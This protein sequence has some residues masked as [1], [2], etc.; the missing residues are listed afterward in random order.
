MACGFCATGQA[1]FERQL[2]VGEIV[3]QVVRAR[4]R[5]AARDDP[6]R[7]SNIV[8]M[9]MGEP[10]ANY[11]NTWATVERLHG[12]M[13][14]SARHLTIST[15]GIVPG[16][17][18]LADETLPVNLAVSLHA[19]DDELRDEL[20]PINRRYPLAVLAEAC[21]HYLQVKNRRLSFEWAL[22]DGVNDRGVDA[23]RLAD[24]ALAAAGPREPD[25]AEPDAGLPDPRHPPRAGAGV[26]RPV[27]LARREHH[28]PPE[29]RHRHRRRLRA[30]AGRPRHQR[31]TRRAQPF[32]TLTVRLAPGPPSAPRHAATR[33]PRRPPRPRPPIGGPV[34][35]TDA[36]GPTTESTTLAR[37]GSTWAPSAT[38]DPPAASTA[39]RLA[40][41]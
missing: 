40:R 8:F 13:G 19:A 37:S 2:S 11:D 17:R 18:K 14:I 31:G 12:D 38:I 16:I 41:R 21:E 1:G 35:A 4:Q 10:M 5:A 23:T 30:A 34:P 6:R 15:V 24:Y 28:G 9:G 27:A 32:A 39:S 29:P 25:P 20:V 36:R 3:E 26:P 22:I 7:V 33:P